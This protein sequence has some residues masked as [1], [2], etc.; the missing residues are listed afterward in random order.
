MKIVLQKFLN[1]NIDGK[2]SVNDLMKKFG[3]DE[4][5]VYLFL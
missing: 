3:N 1:S 2:I 4:T 5:Q